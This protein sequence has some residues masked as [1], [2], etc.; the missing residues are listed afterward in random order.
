MLNRRHLRVKVLQVLYAFFQTANDDLAS[1]E[2][3]LILNIKKT[4]EL[5]L[6]Q[7]LLIG[8]LGYIAERFFDER[9]SNNLRQT[10]DDT[11][12]LKF[13]ENRLIKLIRTSESLN[14]A[15][16]DKNISWSN[17]YYLLRKI[18]L[19][20]RR[21]EMYRDYVNK[22]SHTF[23]DEKKFV[24]NIFKTLICDFELLHYFYE[25]RCI[26]W[27]DDWELVYRC[28]VKTIKEAKEGDKDIKLMSVFKENS[29]ESFTRE[30]FNKTVLNSKEFD[31][32]I[33]EKAKN[34][35]IE[36]IA[37]IDIILIKMALTELVK[38]PEIP[39]KVTLNEYIEIS[40]M[41]STQK[42]KI[43][44]NGVLDKLA[45]DLEKEGKIKKSGTGLISKT[46]S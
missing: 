15:C 31:P 20:I 32:M 18:F 6:Y 21:S 33:A 11:A 42:S 27:I 37:I 30:L 43:F 16:K 36:R 9:K 1:G 28:V 24:L 35:D 2:K 17:D 34:W 44:I 7:L 23:E 39:V 10:E 3:E 22:G 5:Y 13:P 41:Y 26:Y 14:K 8:E 25:E 19:H 38:F 12:G 4:F 45:I 46:Y 29:D 40:K